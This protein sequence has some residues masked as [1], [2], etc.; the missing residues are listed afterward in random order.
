MDDMMTKEDIEKYLNE[1]NKKLA[2]RG[3]YGEIIM[4]GGA[5]LTVIFNARNSTHDID[6]LFRPSKELREIISEIANEHNLKDDWLNDGV[7]G[8]FTD[9][10]K[11]DLYKEY[12]NL[13]VYSIDAEGLLALKLT[14]ARLDSNDMKDSITLMKYLNIKNEEQLFGIIE[15]YTNKNQQTAK[16][17]YFTLEAFN[18]YMRQKDREKVKTAVPE[19]K[20][21]MNDLIKQS[22]E[23]KKQNQD[24][25][26]ENDSVN[27]E[28][29]KNKKDREL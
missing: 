3:K 19:M 8:F 28:K 4:A 1:V 18:K 15:K 5:S 13:S 16:C 11:A 6:A 12:S 22:Q 10:M 29:R 9:K 24:L 20:T 23:L 27:R 7:K 26:K 14:S 2:E 25:K 21:N 17:Q